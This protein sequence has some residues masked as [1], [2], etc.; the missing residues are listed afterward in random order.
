M[1]REQGYNI[2]KIQ[3]GIPSFDSTIL[4]NSG[5]NYTSFFSKFDLF[6]IE[7]GFQKILEIDNFVEKKFSI[8]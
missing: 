7:N 6:F 1:R 2:S 3:A 8:I 5:R 4:K